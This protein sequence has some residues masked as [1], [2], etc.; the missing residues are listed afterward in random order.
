MASTSRHSTVHF[1][2]VG[3]AAQDESELIGCGGRIALLPQGHSEL[4][5]GE[6]VFRVKSKHLVVADDG[7][8]ILLL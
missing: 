7:F 4:A 6:Y 2:V 8:I 5:V 3:A 1:Q